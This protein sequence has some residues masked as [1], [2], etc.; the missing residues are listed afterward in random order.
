MSDK[1]ELGNEQSKQVADSALACGLADGDFL[2]C[3]IAVG[4]ALRAKFGEADT[5]VGGGY[6]E[7]WIPFRGVEY[8]LVMKVNRKLGKADS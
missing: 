5:G 2:E 8:K 7:F 6:A 4:E 1:E 3:Y